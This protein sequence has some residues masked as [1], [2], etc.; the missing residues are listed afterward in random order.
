MFASVER[1]DDG[2]VDAGAIIDELARAED[3]PRETLRLASE[4][5]AD[6]AAP[7]V[8]EIQ[9]YLAA[10]AADETRSNALFYIFL[11]LGEWREK[12]A[13]RPL[14]R[15]LRRPPDEIDAIFGFGIVETAHRVM[16]AVFDGDPRPIHDIVLDPE[17]DEYVRSRMCEALAM[18]VVAGRLAREDAA[19][20]LRECYSDL[21]P[22]R[23]NFVWSG[24]QSAIA[25]LGAA[26]L[27]P[28]VE[29]A[30]ERG[31]VDP[32]WLGFADF[33]EDLA[34]ARAHPD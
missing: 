14:A 1:E 34:R 6:L 7:F 17:A 16:A 26:E 23:D 27:A 30:F 4:R 32:Q 13:Y 2:G 20:F 29:Q 9:T 19:Q 21:R 28:L 31:S 10:P 22:V 11:L 15:L 8:A 5:R 3:L 33:G 12:S 24:W 25:M 18:L